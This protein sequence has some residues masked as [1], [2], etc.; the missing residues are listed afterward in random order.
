MN[1]PLTPKKN[2]SETA[3]ST[4][5]TMTFLVQT[6]R[7]KQKKL[8]ALPKKK[9]HKSK[10]RFKLLKRKNQVHPRMILRHQTPRPMM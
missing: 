6:K 8:Q 4:S 1:H 5:C 9:T 3:S 7:K 2:K 10:V